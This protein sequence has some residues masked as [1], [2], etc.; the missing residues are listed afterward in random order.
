MKP[1]L[2][3]PLPRSGETFV[4]R[5]LSTDDLA[6]FQ[7]YRHDPEVGRYQGWSPVSDPE[8]LAFLAEMHAAPL[9]RP[10]GWT[11]IGIADP[12]SQRLIGD[13]GV[14]LDLDLQYAEIGIT[15]GRPSQRR[16]V[17]TAALREVIAL[18]FESSPVERVIGITDAR[19]V[20]SVRLLERVGMRKVETQA[21]VFRGEPCV[22]YVYAT[23][24]D[25]RQPG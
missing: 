19:N 3:D 5:R 18:I 13:I 20:F 12:D 11:Q 2:V 6:A 15:L 4:L 23:T 17:A 14:Y 1:P 8:A 9:P 10:G 7:S 24:R 22:E 16:G 25:E 21:A